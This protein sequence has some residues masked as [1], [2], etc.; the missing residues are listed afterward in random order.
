MV[1]WSKS[2]AWRNFYAKED[3]APEEAWVSE[4]E[5]LAPENLSVHDTEFRAIALAALDA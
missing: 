4:W 3:R 2:C 5:E 1:L